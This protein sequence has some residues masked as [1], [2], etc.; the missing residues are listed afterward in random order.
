VASGHLVCGYS[1][2]KNISFSKESFKKSLLN[3]RKDAGFFAEY[4]NS[5]LGV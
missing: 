2:V 4:I 5:H 1:E 3:L